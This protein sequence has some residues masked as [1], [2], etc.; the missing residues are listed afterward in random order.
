MKRDMDLIRRI[1]MELEDKDPHNPMISMNNVH[2]EV[3]R[4]HALLLMEAGLAQGMTQNMVAG[5]PFAAL[6]RL[7]WAGHDF[8]DASRNDTIWKKAKEQVLR[9]GMSFTFELLRDWLKSEISKGFATL[10]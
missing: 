6:Y 7:T 3:F 10:G 5:Q 8:L 9:P 1:C 2:D 4:E